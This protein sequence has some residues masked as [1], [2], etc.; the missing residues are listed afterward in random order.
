MNL[1]YH[2]HGNLFL[3]LLLMIRG[4]HKH[5]PE[6]LFSY[7]KQMFEIPKNAPPLRVFLFIRSSLSCLLLAVSGCDIQVSIEGWQVCSCVSHRQR[8]G[9]RRS[10]RPELRPGTSEWENWNDSRK[11]Y[12]KPTGAG[13][14]F[15]EELLASASH[16]YKKINKYKCCMSTDETKSSIPDANVRQIFFF[17][18]FH[19]GMTVFP[20]ISSLCSAFLPFIQQ[21]Q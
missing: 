7:R 6:P 11:R 5:F 1:W 18:T 19:W 20:G 16:K 13:F 21:Q 17:S 14:Q 3:K 9:W 8:R 15:T 10:G 2:H 4:N 12:L